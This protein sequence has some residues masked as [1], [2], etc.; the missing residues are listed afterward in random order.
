M[1]AS[2]YHQFVAVNGH[3][4]IEV[5]KNAIKQSEGIDGMMMEATPKNTVSKLKRSPAPVVIKVRPSSKW[6]NGFEEGL[7]A[8]KGRMTVLA[9]WPRA[10]SSKFVV[11]AINATPRGGYLALTLP[12]EGMPPES[13]DNLAKAIKKNPVMCY[14][15]TLVDDPVVRYLP[16]NPDLSLL[17]A[18]AENQIEGILFRFEYGQINKKEA[19]LLADALRK[20]KT[21]V[22]LE[23]FS[24]KASQE[25]MDVIFE[26]V[27]SVNQSSP[28]TV[29]LTCDGAEIGK[30][31]GKAKFKE[32]ARD[33]IR[34]VNA[35]AWDD[36]SSGSDPLSD[37]DSDTIVRTTSSEEDS[38]ADYEFD[39]RGY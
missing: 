34:F 32:L 24:L 11:S 9:M 31:V 17:A 38:D 26:A 36:D 10:E 14:V 1:R 22:S 33:G 8:R 15:A 23:I 21:P 35:R 2:E 30:T 18:C 25:G 5:A 6:S 12:P 27:R 7:A 28:G 20:F 29:A 4:P 37:D 39:L 16:N 3:T 19:Q 13:T